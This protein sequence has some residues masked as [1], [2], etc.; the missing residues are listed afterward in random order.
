[1]QQA[2]RAELSPLGDPD[3]STIF[4]VDQ[5]YSNET[6]ELSVALEEDGNIGL[7]TP[8][9]HTAALQ[10]MD[11]RGGPIQH[12]NRILRALC[13]REQRGGRLSKARLMRLIEVAVAASHLPN[14]FGRAACQV[15]W[16]ED[17]SG[18][19]RPP[20]YTVVPCYAF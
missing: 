7:N 15:G 11:Q 17:D 10:H 9:H 8:G 2:R 5:H 1:V 14:I 18:K 20:H 12:A 4:Q 3:R 16:A 13:R 19:V 6:I